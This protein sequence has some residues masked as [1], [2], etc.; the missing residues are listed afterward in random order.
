MKCLR[1]GRFSGERLGREG[2]GRSAADVHGVTV[3]SD[4]GL[5]PCRGQVELIA[6][7]STTMGNAG[8]RESERSRENEGPGYEN[9]PTVVPLP[10]GSLTVDRPLATAFFAEKSEC[11][12]FSTLPCGRREKSGCENR[13]RVSASTRL[14]DNHYPNPDTE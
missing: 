3:R 14:K 11:D 4:A 7:F 6:P 1:A 9:R 13:T 10:F 12:G 2:T 8:E 5:A